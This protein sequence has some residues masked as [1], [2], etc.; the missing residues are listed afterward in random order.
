MVNPKR[1]AA[2]ARKWQKLAAIGRKRITMPRTDVEAAGQQSEPSKGHFIIYTID[3]RC[4]AVPLAYHN[5][6]IFQ[7]LFRMSEDEFVLP[8]NGPIMMPCDAVFM[9]YIVSL[10]QRTVPKDL[11][12]ALLLSLAT[13]R[14]STSSWLDQPRTNPAVLVHGY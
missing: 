9:D 5:S 3:G 2:M 8:S 7:E 14:C 12:R 1:H 11:E 6:P 10:L 4:F 13:S